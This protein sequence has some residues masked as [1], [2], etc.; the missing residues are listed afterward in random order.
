MIEEKG[1]Q[2]PKENKTTTTT[3]TK[4][5]KSQ[6]LPKTVISNNFEFQES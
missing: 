3:T 6:I 1:S 5:K 4:N 2:K